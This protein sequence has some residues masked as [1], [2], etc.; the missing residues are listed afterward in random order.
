MSAPKISQATFPAAAI[1]N[2]RGPILAG[3]DIGP[4]GS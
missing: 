3:I 4:S 2:L 1:E